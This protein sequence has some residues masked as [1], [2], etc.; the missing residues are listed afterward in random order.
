MKENNMKNAWKIIRNLLAI[1]GAVTILGA[2]STS[3]Y[4]VMELGQAEP[5]MV[6]QSMIIGVL[7]FLPAAIEIFYNIY[8]EGKTNEN[9]G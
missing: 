2:V 3:D 9:N 1:A 5:T 4:Y 8:K 7:M 6:W